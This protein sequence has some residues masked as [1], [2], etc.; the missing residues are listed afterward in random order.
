[1]LQTRPPFAPRRRKLGGFTLVELMVVV[2]I[3]AILLGI[4]VPALQSL[5]AAN[6]LTTATDS[7]ATALNE[8]RSEAAKLNLNVTL[9][10]TGSWG[11][12]WTMAVVPPAGGPVPAGLP[13]TLRTAAAVPSGLT[14]N[15][16]AAFAAGVTFDPTGRLVGAAGEFVICQNSGPPAG[17]AQMVT[18]A[19]SGRVRVAQNNTA[20]NPIADD[21]T[22]VTNCTP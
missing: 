9:T 16:S 18:I 21:G 1:M 8:A 19:T 13:S 22:P 20:G 14:L 17:K 10:P 2:L 11:G 3:T 4:G 15:S 5:V 12:G 7:L 6:Q